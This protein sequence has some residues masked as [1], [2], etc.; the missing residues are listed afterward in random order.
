MSTLTR[1]DPRFIRLFI[2]SVRSMFSAKA[3][4]IIDTSLDLRL[5]FDATLSLRA[6]DGRF[7][8]A[9]ERT[10]FCLRE[11]DTGT[12][13]SI[14]IRPFLCP[15]SNVIDRLLHHFERATIDCEERR[16]EKYI[17]QTKVCKCLHIKD[18]SAR[19]RNS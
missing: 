15:P 16:G 5:R 2:G 6:I 13:A 9:A 19:L 11:K 3:S 8:D 12:T 14:L 4:V 1:S 7:D 17:E 18:H 10:S